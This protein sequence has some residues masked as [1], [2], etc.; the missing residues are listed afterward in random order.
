MDRHELNRMFD[1]LA[2]APE[3]ERELLKQL[4]QNGAR[5]N[6]PMKNW[7]R[8][9]IG[10]AAAALL[11]TA[12]G[13]SYSLI[14][15]NI[16]VDTPQTAQDIVG[17]GQP[18]WK[19]TELLDEQGR[20]QC[21]WPNRETAP[22]D[23]A[24]AQ[25]LL[26][27]YL[28]ECGY[29]WQI[30]D[31]TFTVEGYLL[32]ENTNTAKF[33]YTVEHLGGFGDGAVDWTHG[34]LNNGVYKINTMFAPQSTRAD[35]NWFGSRTYVNTD[36]STPEK[37]YI[38]E[39]A[40]C[41]DSW[42]AEDGIGISFTIWGE[43]GQGDPALSVDLEL[44]GLK[45]LPAV[46]AVDPATGE[47]LAE[48]SAIGIKLYRIDVDKIDYLALDY[49]DGTRYVVS[50]DANGLDNADYGHGT[51]SGPVS[52]YVFNRLVDPSQVAAVLVN[53]QRYSVAS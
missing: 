52:R 46:P 18:S 5:R 9:V 1:G 37:L 32:D 41:S 53:N 47:T 22:V 6:K 8:I 28:P 31:Y 35:R 49:I 38:V 29:Q 27:D 45:S 4:L 51:Y 2:P 19:E 10:A 42:K 30:A 34:W 36:R 44:P 7:K 26:V 13:A 15:Q 14:R 24:Q 11:V 20:L 25:A 48:L 16:N 17:S 50:D 33:C 23:G 21:Y 40:A 3:R 43:A 12:A 39:S